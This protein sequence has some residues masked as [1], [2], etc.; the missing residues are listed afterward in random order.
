MDLNFH[1]FKA[2]E[3]GKLIS[4]LEK[5]G[6]ISNWEYTDLYNLFGMMDACICVS[7]SDILKFAMLLALYAKEQK[8]DTV[9][10]TDIIEYT[11]FLAF[12]IDSTCVRT[13]YRIDSF[14]L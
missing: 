12:Y 3:S 2:I 13:T 8:F 5:R 9:V 4:D 14:A 7:E 1:T 6:V 10:Y 11:Q